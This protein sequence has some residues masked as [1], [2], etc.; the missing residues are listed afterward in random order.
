MKVEIGA[1]DE[2]NAAVLSIETE[3]GFVQERYK[4]VA[5]DLRSHVNIPGFRKGKSTFTD[6]D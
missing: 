4:Q 1:R 3:P 2:N 5:R 6:G